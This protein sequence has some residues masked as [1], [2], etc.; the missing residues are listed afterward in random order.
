MGCHVNNVQF[1][2]TELTPD[3]EKN[4]YLEQ[5]TFQLNHPTLLPVNGWIPNI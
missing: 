3:S 1:K 4:I 2:D 5:G